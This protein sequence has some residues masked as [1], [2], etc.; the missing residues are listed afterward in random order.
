MNNILKVGVT[1]C[2]QYEVYRHVYLPDTV[3][4]FGM[5]TKPITQNIYT[6]K[7]AIFLRSDF[8]ILKIQG[9]K[10]IAIWR[11]KEIKFWHKSAQDIIVTCP[12]MQLKIKYFYGNSPNQFFEPF[13]F[14]Q[15]SNHTKK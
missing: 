14:N 12:P 8:D 11:I 9:Y 10:L 15:S 7:E 3:K 2:Y 1:I 13:H 4:G 6:Y 5:T